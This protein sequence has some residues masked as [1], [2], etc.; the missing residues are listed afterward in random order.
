MISL[1]AKYANRLIG[2]N[3]QPINK[4]DNHYTITDFFKIFVRNL[5]RGFVKAIFLQK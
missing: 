3:H 5:T 1:S 4:T 2:N